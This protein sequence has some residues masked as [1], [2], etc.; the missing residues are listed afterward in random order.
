MK[1]LSYTYRF[2]ALFMAA[3]VFLS[4]VGFSLD[5]HLCQGELRSVSL[6]GK[7][8]NCY[9]LAGYDSPQSCSKHKKTKATTSATGCSLVKKEC[10]KDQFHYFQSDIDFQTQTAD[11]NIT[12]QI[13]KFVIAFVTVFFLDKLSDYPI[14]TSNY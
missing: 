13:Q 14:I 4:S 3:M 9:E 6:L 5:M 7:A 10:C 1:K 12:P 8:K 2:I 11:L